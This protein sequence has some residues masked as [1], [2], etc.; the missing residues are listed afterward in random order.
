M[1]LDNSVFRY[2]NTN[3]ATKHGP[4]LL[5]RLRKYAK[6]IKEMFATLDEYTFELDLFDGSDVC[7]CTMTVTREAFEE[8]C[9][10]LFKRI[11]DKVTTAKN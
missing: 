11:E 2:K 5:Y 8:H 4:R 1:Y 6:R 10:P 9:A 7:D 3:S